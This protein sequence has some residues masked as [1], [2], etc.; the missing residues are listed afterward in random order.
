MVIT[1]KW[2]YKVKLDELGESFAPVARLED[3]RIFLAFIAHMNMVVY[4]MDV[5]TAFLNGN[6]WEEVYVCQPDRNTILTIVTQWDLPWWEKSKTGN[7]DKEG[8][9]LS[10]LYHGTVNWGLW[11]PKDSLIALTAFAD[12]DHE[13]KSAALFQY[14]SC[15]YCSCSCDLCSNPWIEIYDLTDFGFCFKQN[16]NVIEITKSA[17]AYDASN[18]QLPVQSIID[19]R[20]HLIKDIVENSW[21]CRIFTPETLKTNGIYEVDE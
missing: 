15:I 2:I 8:K 17:I 14:G 18:V 3:I 9:P 4:Q 10:V 5:K 12:M 13:V 20:F 19:F 6:L 21:E 1:L 7:E 11:Y 16:S